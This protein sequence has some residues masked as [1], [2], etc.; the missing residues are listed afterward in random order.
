MLAE[1]LLVLS[2]HSSSF[3]IPSP[4]GPSTATT[5]V[6]SPHVREY[7][8]PG[9]ISSLNSLG[10]LA[11]R[12]AKIRDWAQDVQRRG[13]EAI[14]AENLSSSRKGKQREVQLSADH[15]VPS[16]YLSTLASSLLRTL[17]DYNLLVVETEAR[18]LALDPGMIQDQGYVPLSN[19][20]A[21]FDLWQAPLASLVNLVDQLST[22]GPEGSTKTPG[23]LLDLIT[24]RTQTGNP[25]L[26]KMYQ[27]LL[28]SL[29]YLF[30]THLVSFLLYGLAPSRSTATSPALALDV[31]ADPSSPKYRIYKLNEDLIPASIDRRTQ[32]SILYIGRVAATLRRQGREL[33]K[34][35]VDG[36]RVEIMAVKGLA[37]ADGLGEAMQRARAEVG[38]WLWKHI[39]TG[40]QIADAI[41][42]LSNF[43]LVRKAD[44]ALSLLREISKLPLD[45][46]VLS[47][48][49]SSS[50]VIREQDLDL[51]L[52]RASVGTSAEH[53]I[54]LDDLKFKMKRGPL[55]AIIPPS[56]KPSKNIEQE[57]EGSE[58][59]IKQLFSSAILGTPFELSTSITWPLDLFLSPGS[60]STYSDIHSYL[61]AFR[62]THLRVQDTWTSLSASQRLR[63][64]WTGTNEG[65][66][67]EEQGNRT[68]LGR[69]AWGT[70]RLM[71]W[72]LDQMIGHFMDDIIDVQHKRLL[73]QL[74]LVD[75]ETGGK[76][77]LASSTRGSLRGS[78]GPSVTSSRSRAG[79][80]YSPSL[81]GGRPQS[82]LSETHTWAD[83][84]AGRSNKAPP[85][86]S[87]STASYLDFLTLRQIHAR[88]L[89]LVREGLLITDIPMISIIRDI[90]DVCKRFTSV[91]E[92]WG[93]DVI[94]MLLD[95]GSGG[96]DVGRDA[97]NTVVEREFALREIN[98]NLHDLLLEFF[99]ALLDTRNPGGNQTEADRSQPGQVDTTT[100]S[101][102]SRMTHISRMM[103]RHGS[104]K[105]ATLGGRSSASRPGA[106]AVGEKSRD[107]EM[108]SEVMLSRHIEQ[109]LLRL[110][111]NN[112]LTEWRQREDEGVK[113]L[114]SVLPEGG[115]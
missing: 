31:G 13:R 73:E 54:G 47:N 40:P 59:P 23:Q 102:T 98:E 33:P 106:G 49:H 68:R 77:G 62:D 93:G 79:T 103:S 14:L 96:A 34:S 46:L 37:E 75:M 11:F 38:E 48:P 109:L 55:R 17:N 45:K 25:F 5:L 115:L 6:V 32:Q 80:G 65:G 82:P 57:G 15:G 53:D 41:E 63:R 30:L 85:T 69:L 16:Q 84:T 35:L 76:D 64:K 99:S 4:P 114:R 24:E 107:K 94:P 10:Q 91:V 111:F 9:E 36:V 51:A 110:D 104:F 18:I 71:A 86:P 66:T 28:S 8:H 74:E 39:L 27:S 58:S 95:E 60:M 19:L 113:D 12:Y 87:K 81:A 3:F 7:L 52:L 44:F 88:H 2:G 70:L 112:V 21:T 89:S 67:I 61:F 50:S 56:A 72:W 90:L 105:S 42:S 29:V 1:V 22:T 78:L 83:G 100:F 26:E 20:V 108:E 97:V 101:R 92:R 43:F